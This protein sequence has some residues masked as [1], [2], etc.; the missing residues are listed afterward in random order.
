MGSVHAKDRDISIVNR[1]SNIR[2]I[3]NNIFLLFA[4]P[5]PPFFFYETAFASLLCSSRFDHH[6]RH[7]Y[8]IV[9]ISI[10]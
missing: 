5:S 7:N 10:D 4:P 6:R 2:S 9:S 8:F 3:P 1:R